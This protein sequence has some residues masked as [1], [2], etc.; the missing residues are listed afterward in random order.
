[1]IRRTAQ[2][3]LLVGGLALVGQASA[4]GRDAAVVGAV[5]GATVAGA[6][7]YGSRPAPAPVYVAPPPP[8]PQ[9][10]YYAPPP[11][12][13]YEPVYYGYRPLPPP[14]RYYGPPHGWHQGHRW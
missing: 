2:I 14:P 6:M 13:Y 9:V 10:V 1:M 3:V 4:H 8:P 7:I 12:V 5:V 11:P